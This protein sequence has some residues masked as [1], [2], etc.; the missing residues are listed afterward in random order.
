MVALLKEGENRVKFALKVD[1]LQLN[2]TYWI[3]IHL[4]STD[5]DPTGDLNT[6]TDPPGSA[7]LDFFTA[8]NDLKKKC[9]KTNLRLQIGMFLTSRKGCQKEH[10]LHFKGLLMSFSKKCYFYSVHMFIQWLSDQCPTHCYFSSILQCTH[11]DLDISSLI[12]IYL[13]LII[14]FLMILKWQCFAS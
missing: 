14:I 9:Q 10:Y 1:F 7:T 4:S 12:I 11:R 6:G 13:L 3:R 2:F 8:H 5:P